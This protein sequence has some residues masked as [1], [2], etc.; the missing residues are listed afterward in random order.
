MERL[1]LLLAGMVEVAFMTALFGT[2][3]TC[4]ALAVC[5]GK[6]LR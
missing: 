1:V 3:V 4:G 2:A 6:D 5:R